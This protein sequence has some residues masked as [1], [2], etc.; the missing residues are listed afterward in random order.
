MS[1]TPNKKSSETRP[2][3]GCRSGLRRGSSFHRHCRHRCRC[4]KGCP[5]F[6]PDPEGVSSPLVRLVCRHRDCR[7]GSRRFRRWSC[8]R[9]GRFRTACSRSRCSLRF[10]PAELNRCRA[11]WRRRARTLWRRRARILCGVSR[12]TCH[13]R[14]C[15]RCSHPRAKRSCP[16]SRESYS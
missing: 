16:N 11:C 4:R 7:S 6:C 1:V 15:V 9:R 5:F 3:L 2:R 8:R 14:S 10:R 13:R 12:R